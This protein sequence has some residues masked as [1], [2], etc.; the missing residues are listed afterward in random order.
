[1]FVL[2]ENLFVMNNTDL[3]SVYDI[4]PRYINIFVTFEM[5]KFILNLDRRF[6]LCNSGNK[7][8]NDI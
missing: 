6:S 8:M 7:K 3:V 1:M 4:V 2:K 5:R